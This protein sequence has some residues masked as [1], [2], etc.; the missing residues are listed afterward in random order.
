MHLLA[1]LPLLACHD[2]KAPADDATC[3]ARM[4]A[5]LDA[6]TRALTLSRDGEAL[7]VLP[8]DGLALGTERARDDARSYDPVFPDTS[9]RWRA[10][11][12]VGAAGD[13]VFHVEWEGGTTGTLT[14]AESAAGRFSLRIA[15]DAGGPEAVVA[16]RVG[17]TVDANEGY[18]GLNS[19]LL[20]KQHA[21]RLVLTK[22]KRGRK[23]MATAG[24]SQPGTAIQGE[25]YEDDNVAKLREPDV[26]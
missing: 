26:N 17:G 22:P 18:Y 5:T 13:G 20:D 25:W 19:K 12:S 8:A 10:L 7:L 9:T 21:D 24:S 6:D 23:P 16:Y 1:L 3:T 14:L 15:P 11:A 4:C 2:D